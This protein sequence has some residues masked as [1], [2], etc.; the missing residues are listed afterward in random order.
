MAII[1]L[2]GLD[3]TGKSTVAQLYKEQGYEILHLSAP[4]KELS[5]PGY[6]GPSYLDQMVEIIQNGASRDIVLDRTHYGE[7]IWPNIYSRKPHLNEE[8]MDVLREIEE[9]VGCTR[10]LMHDPNVEAHWQRCIDNKEPL[11]KAQF[12]KARM[13]YERM[14]EKYSFERKT[15]KDY[16]ETK[17]KGDSGNSKSDEAIQRP[18]DP[19]PQAGDHRI[20]TAVGN[21]TENRSPEQH[22][23]EL[24]NAIND[25][26]SKR[27]LKSKG[28]VYDHLERDVRNFLND[29]L[30]KI[31]GDGKSNDLSKEE[32]ATLKLFCK[33]LK[34]KENGK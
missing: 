26:L 14:A 28:T 20:A 11:N 16:V 1:L 17:D 3:R 21:A 10:I 27:I 19:A 34:E 18:A 2:E 32:I 5:M 33:R 25:V 4:P 7:L 8:D 9:S 6:T 22:K 13:L 12:L 24:A 29:R 23:L 30:G 15:L 31:F